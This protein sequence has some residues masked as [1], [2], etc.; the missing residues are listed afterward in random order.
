[1]VK[2][3]FKKCAIDHSV[4]IKTYGNGNVILIVYVHDIILTGSDTTGIAETKKY[5]RKH[6]VA[7]DMKRLKYFLGIEFTYDHNKVALSQRKYVLDLL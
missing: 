6:L 7:K 5:M 1:M 4:F 3:G 2:S